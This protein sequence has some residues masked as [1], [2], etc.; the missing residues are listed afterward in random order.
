ME[1]DVT[2]TTELETQGI[3]WQAVPTAWGGGFQKIIVFRIGV[4]VS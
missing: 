3:S 1:E 2:A 4:G